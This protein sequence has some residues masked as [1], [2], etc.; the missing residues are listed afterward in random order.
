MCKASECRK[1]MAR[2]IGL[3]GDSFGY[4][5]NVISVF[6]KGIAC[7][8]IAESEAMEAIGNGFPALDRVAAET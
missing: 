4:I 3:A 1:E 5:G 7:S 8:L 6:N 2:E